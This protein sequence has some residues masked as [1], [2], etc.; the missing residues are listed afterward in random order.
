MATTLRPPGFAS[1][2][3]AGADRFDAHLKAS[4]STGVFELCHGWAV[5]LTSSYETERMP[6][7]ALLQVHKIEYCNTCQVRRPGIGCLRNDH[8]VAPAADLTG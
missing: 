4:A 8:G 7:Q 5:G 2:S 1:G 3:A 6:L